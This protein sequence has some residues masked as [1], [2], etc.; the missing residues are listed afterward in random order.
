LIRLICD[1]FVSTLAGDGTPR[2]GDGLFANARF[3][4][5]NA[6]C[7]SPYGDLVVVDGGNSRVRLLT[8]GHVLTIAG[9]GENGFKDGKPL[10]AQFNLPTAA[11]WTR[12]GL[13][14]IADGYNQRVRVLEDENHVPSPD[15]RIIVDLHEKAEKFS[16]MLGNH[17]VPMKGRTWHFPRAVLHKDARAYW[18]TLYWQVWQP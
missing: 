7:L 14:F 4:A 16:L 10:K 15:L 18:K 9:N 13:L 17:Q 1:G 12:S 11:V 3:N 2:F 5:P 8:N 6:L